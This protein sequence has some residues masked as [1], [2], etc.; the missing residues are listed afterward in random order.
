MTHLGL[1]DGLLE[2]QLLRTAAAASSGGAELGECLATAGRIKGTD[3]TSW[4]DEWTSTANSVCTDRCE[5]PVPS[6]I[7]A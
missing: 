3:L 5:S 4:Y 6:T 7:I 2:A 1:K